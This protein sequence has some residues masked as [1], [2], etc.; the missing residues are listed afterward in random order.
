MI[1][2]NS[3]KEY[4]D[5]D[6]N[7]IECAQ[8]YLE[9]KVVFRG[10]RN[11]IKISDGAKL[12]NVVVHMDC[13]DG[14]LIIGAHNKIWTP[15]KATIRI[16]HRSKVVIGN[17]VSSTSSAFISAVE[18]A[19]VEI[20]HDCMFATGITIR[21]DDS[22][23][24][25]DVFSGK[26]INPARHVKILDH[27]WLGDRCSVLSGAM[28]G[29]GS[30]IGL[31]SIVKGVIPN[32]CIAVGSPAKVIKKNIAWERPH[33]SLTKPWNKDDSSSITKSL[34]WNITK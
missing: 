28:I 20:G 12:N 14:M 33:L 23:P 8:E 9:C 1:T 29:E 19:N 32:N 5:E 3:I 13:D 17:N 7:I 30:V 31:G 22:H 11:V 26:R 21:S 25:F 4:S 16:G 34:Y 15:L 10:K 24:I 27:V 18:G 2:L 6:E